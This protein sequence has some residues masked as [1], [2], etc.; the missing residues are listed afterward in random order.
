[1]ARCACQ[2]DILVLSGTFPTFQLIGVALPKPQLEILSG[3]WHIRIQGPHMLISM[4]TRLVICSAM[5]VV[6]A[7]AILAQDVAC[8]SEPL[9]LGKLIDVG[10]YRVHPY[11]IGAGSPAVVIVGAGFSFAGGAGPAGSREVY[12]GM[13]L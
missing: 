1:M 4:R 2:P 13:F 6:F 9:P 5:F 7:I 11:C 3:P 8:K 12:A 10:G